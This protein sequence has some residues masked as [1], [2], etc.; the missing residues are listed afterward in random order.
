MFYCLSL[1]LF[2]YF[3][4]VFFVL[5]KYPSANNEK[6]DHWQ[7]FYISP[8]LFEI[9]RPSTWPVNRDCH[10]NTQSLDNDD[11]GYIRYTYAPV[12]SKVD[13]IKL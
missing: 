8:P 12:I 2:K 10:G 13:K 6:F 7:R 4:S 3:L 9:I 1:L 11:T 5:T